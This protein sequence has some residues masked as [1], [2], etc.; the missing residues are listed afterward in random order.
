ME[1]E[2][3]LDLLELVEDSDLFEVDLLEVEEDSDL[4]EED[5]NLSP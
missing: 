5:M 4:L 3:D 2:D 1:V